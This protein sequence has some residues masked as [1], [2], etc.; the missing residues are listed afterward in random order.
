[1]EEGAQATVGKMSLAGN[2]CGDCALLA[3]RHEG[4]LITD[5]LEGK[6]CDENGNDV[7][8]SVEVGFAVCVVG[9]CGVVRVGSDSGVDG[10]EGVSRWLR[11]GSDG[12]VDHGL[13]IDDAGG[14]SRGGVD[15]SE[16]G[17]VWAK[18]VLVDASGES[19]GGFEFK[20]GDIRA[21]INVALYQLVGDSSLNG[22]W[23]VVVDVCN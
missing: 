17:A 22:E 11:G 23:G 16:R 13:G 12:V 3:R 21:V 19:R 15:D 2:L 7:L 18:G 14:G 20:V 6:R 8:E 1:M 4:S 9:V 5:F 10:D